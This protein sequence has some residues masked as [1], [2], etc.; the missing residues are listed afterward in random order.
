MAILNLGINIGLELFFCYT[1][2]QGTHNFS[3]LWALIQLWNTIF[4]RQKLESIHC[5]AMAE[6]HFEK[7][8]SIWWS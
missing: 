1:Y 3:R 4:L 6:G 8:G 2:W 7:G 5:L